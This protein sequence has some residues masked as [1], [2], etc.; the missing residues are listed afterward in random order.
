MIALYEAWAHAFTCDFPRFLTFSICLLENAFFDRFRRSRVDFGTSQGHVMSVGLKDIKFGLELSK[1]HFLT[2]RAPTTTTT[3]TASTTQ[4]PNPSYNPF[5]S[6]H[7]EKNIAN[8]FRVGAASL[9]GS[10][11]FSCLHFKEVDFRQIAEVLQCGSATRQM[12]GGICL[13]D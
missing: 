4:S 7:S 1:L 3:R 2:P 10:F 6:P 5:G 13:I 12:P 9:A 8:M 11:V